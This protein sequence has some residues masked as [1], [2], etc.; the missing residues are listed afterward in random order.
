MNDVRA[1][2]LT[3]EQMDCINYNSGD[4]LV[5]GVAGAGKSYVVLRRAAKLY[6][7]KKPE[8]KVAI[9]TF[10]NTLVK[11]TDDI[12]KDQLGE[13][14]IEVQTVDSYCYGIY[15]DITGRYFKAG[16]PDVYISCIKDALDK[17]YRNYRAKTRFYEEKYQNFIEEEFKW[18]REKCI[19]KADEYYATDRKGRGGEVRINQGDKEILWAIYTL[20]QQSAQERNYMDFPDMYVTINDNLKKIPQNK[21]IDYIL[22]DE[23]QDLTIGKMRVMKYLAKKSITI[24]ADMAQKIYKT[25][26]TWKEVGIDISG[27]ASKALSKSFRST[28][29]I[30]LLAEDLMQANRNNNKQGEYTD[31][32]LPQAEGE[33]PRLVSCASF[34]AEEKYITSLIEKLLSGEPSVIGLIVRT[35]KEVNEIKRV[36][37]KNGINEYQTITNEKKTNAKWSLLRPGLKI[38]KAHSSKGL[39][40]DHVIIPYVVDTIYPKKL[41]GQNDE[42]TDEYLEMERSLL[43]VAMT[44]ARAS[45]VMTYQSVAKSRFIDEFKPEHYQK[46]SV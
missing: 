6:K 26:F 9:F 46:E 39:E 19:K 1:V 11:F 44:R 29:Q 18:I 3:K 27:R 37:E 22:L 43:Y 30:V 13:G 2:Q 41:Y 10:T 40:F 24:A 42:M 32:V 8:E 16:E 23:A 5:R 38:V 31:A 12:M 4:L 34:F 21:M 15:H 25:S 36:L 17:H 20:Y 14:Q 45:L 28:K 33:L 35:E 7:E